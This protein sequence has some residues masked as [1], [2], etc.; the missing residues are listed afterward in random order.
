MVSNMN[1]KNISALIL[2]VTLLLSA[3]C[4]AITGDT[5]GTSIVQPGDTPVTIITD[6]N[7]TPMWNGFVLIRE[8][9]HG[10]PEDVSVPENVLTTEDQSLTVFFLSGFGS[11]ELN[12][13]VTEIVQV[14]LDGNWY[15]LA[16][17][18]ENSEIQP[19]NLSQREQ[20]LILPPFSMPIEEAEK[21]KHTI[22]LSVLGSLPSGR[23]R[24]VEQFYLE[25]LQLELHTLAYFWVVEPG[26]DRPPES[27]T[28]GSARQGDIVFFVE[29]LYEARRVITDADTMIAMNIENLSGRQYL[30]SKAFLEV[31][32]GRQWVDV[33]F[34]HANLGLLQSWMKNSNVLFLDA[35]LTA[36]DYRLRL[37]VSVFGTQSEIEPE[38]EFTV[39]PDNDAPEPGW[40]KSRLFVSP[41][42]TAKQGTGV[43]IAPGST[44]LNKE[45]TKL[46]FVLTA[47]DHY[48]YG[49]PYG[50]D[51]LLDGIWYSVPFAHGAF[52]SIGYS[53]DPDT[54]LSKRSHAIY[55]AQSVGVLP[56]GHYRMTK[57]FDLVGPET[58]EWGGPVFIA[59]ETVFAEFIVEETL[60]WLG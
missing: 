14:N 41:Y 6:P 54:E 58:T 44:V 3:A 46:D 37:S 55:P 27:R 36:G 12:Y 50:I 45:K 21:T 40:E 25:R 35:P 28:S 15:T 59:N 11:D 9:Y 43:T 24:L 19:I 34:R 30:A 60:V 8:N 33:P 7:G 42:N 4:G 23:Y 18:S 13:G 39:Y 38:Y 51:V 53:I 20:P 29:S 26:E 47:E 22:D 31:K 17:G 32:Q 2:I 5:P 49:E 10:R 48:S 52:V 1:I 16:T 56:A 57:V